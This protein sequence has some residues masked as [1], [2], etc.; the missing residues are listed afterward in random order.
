MAEFEH[1]VDEVRSLFDRWIEDNKRCEAERNWSRLADYFA[2]DAVY[3]YTM[4]AGG[5]RV[6]RGRD[7]IRRLV[8]ERDM[9]GF[10]GWTFPYEWV[11]IDGS[12]VMTKWWNQAPVSHEDGTPYRVIGVSCIELNND[13]EIQT[14]HDCFDLAALLEMVREVNRVR[15]ARIRIPGAVEMESI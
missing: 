6:A 11:V 3:Q 15:G 13:L 5:L 2:V 4:G 8:M 7:K 14:M 9:E 10:D 12:R 1:T